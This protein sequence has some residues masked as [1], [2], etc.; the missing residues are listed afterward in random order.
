MS[1][2]MPYGY[3]WSCFSFGAGLVLGLR[4]FWD[5]NMYFLFV[6]I[7]AVGLILMVISFVQHSNRSIREIEREHG[8]R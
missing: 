4:R 8:L 6:A 5:A 7:T 3:S 2:V 1:K